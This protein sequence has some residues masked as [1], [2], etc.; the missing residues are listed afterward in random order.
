MKLENYNR[1]AVS[2]A[3]LLALAH[4]LDVPPVWLLADPTDAKAAVPITSDHV[5]DPW[6]AILWTVGRQRLDED[7]P[8]SGWTTA[9]TPLA[10]VWQA[11]AISGELAERIRY[12]RIGFQYTV[13]DDD[14]P[15]DQHDAEVAA[16]MDRRS[17]D[18]L[19]PLLNA[20]ND[21]GYVAPPLPESVVT[22][23]HELGVSLPDKEN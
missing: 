8:S 3:E 23:A 11:A 19:V 1:E 17:L 5:R 7:A 16:Q 12:R 10:W 22:R 18:R 20:L 4:A 14:G 21:D 9:A 13:V 2:V 15:H 6:S